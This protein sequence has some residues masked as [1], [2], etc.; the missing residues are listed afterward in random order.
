MSDTHAFLA[1][2]TKALKAY[3]GTLEK[4]LVLVGGRHPNDWWYDP[5]SHQFLK[6]PNRRH[7]DYHPDTVRVTTLVDGTLRFR[8]GKTQVQRNPDGEWEVRYGKGFWVS[9]QEVANDE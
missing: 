3:T 2:L 6:W 7:Y 4:G 9:V 1:D 8:E 5:G